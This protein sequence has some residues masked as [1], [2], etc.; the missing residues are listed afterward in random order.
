M[1]GQTLPDAEMMAGPQAIARFIATGDE[2]V[3]AGVFA[4]RD[5][6]IVENFAPHAFTGPDA[7]AS[8]TRAMR[9]H[10]E[11]VSELRHSFGEACDFSRA[12]ELAFFSLPTQWTGMARGRRFRERGGWAFALIASDGAWRVRNYAWAVTEITAG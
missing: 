5:I 11:G 3:L 2:S 7:I 4:D 10:L 1:T 12:G 6:A 8:W 9:G